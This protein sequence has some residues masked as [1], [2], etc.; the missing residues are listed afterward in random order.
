MTY[1][2][3]VEFEWNDPTER[4][5]FERLV[6]G[7]PEDVTGRVARILSIDAAGARAIEVWHSPEDARRFAELSAPDL[8]GVALPAPTRVQGFEVDRF[9]C[10]GQGVGD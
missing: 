10:V 4:V 3:I 5:A 7:G 6:S 9:S 2:T 8:G 1:C